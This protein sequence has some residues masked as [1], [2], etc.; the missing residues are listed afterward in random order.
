MCRCNSPCV[1][2][3]VLNSLSLYVCTVCVYVIFSCVCRCFYV[4][5][6][7]CGGQSLVC[8]GVSMRMFIY[9]C[10]F[11]GMCVRV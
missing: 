10:V 11:V 3:R 2:L 9:V 8:L 1:S 4:Y 7:V 5:T 6:R